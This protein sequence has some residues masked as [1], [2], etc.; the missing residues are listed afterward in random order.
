MVP[1]AGSPILWNLRL[2]KTPLVAWRALGTQC[3]LIKDYTNHLFDTPDS[4]HV[5]HKELVTLTIRLEHLWKGKYNNDAGLLLL[6][7]LDK[8]K[9]KVIVRI[10]QIQI[11]INS[12][13]VSSWTLEAEGGGISSSYSADTTKNKT[14]TLLIW[15]GDLQL[16][17]ESQPQRMWAPKVREAL[18]K[19]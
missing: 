2:L 18:R 7:S 16:K 3:R 9:W 4:P 1:G 10:T 15:L 19:V 17:F 14:W 5:R 12:L 6:A 11:C 8:Q 13:K